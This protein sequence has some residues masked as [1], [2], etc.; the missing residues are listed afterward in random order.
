MTRKKLLY[1]ALSVIIVFSSIGRMVCSA[2]TPSGIKAAYKTVIDQA[3]SDY[4]YSD[5]SIM[6]WTYSIYDVDKDGVPE[7]LIDDEKPHAIRQIKVYKYN[8]V[9]SYM[10]DFMPGYSEMCAYPDGSG[11]A[12]LVQG[13]NREFIE[14]YAYNGGFVSAGNLTDI[15]SVYDANEY[16]NPEELYL[17]AYALSECNVDDYSLLNSVFADD[18]IKV[19]LNGAEIGFDQ[20]PVMMNDRVLVPIRAIF[21]AMGYTVNWNDYNN[22]ATAQRGYDVITV[23]LNNSNITYSVNGGSGTYYCDVPPQLIS[24]RVLVPIRAVSECAGCSVW[25]DDNNQIVNINS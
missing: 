5:D 18:D 7:L 24:D 11:I 19:V 21:E 8:G 6:T 14:L 4:L 16:R 10:G 15:F 3:Y 1:V 17:G 9:I 23:Q 22:T 25:W 20:P 13:K 12:M 2:D